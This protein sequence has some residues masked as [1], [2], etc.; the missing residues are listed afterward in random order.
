MDLIV[1]AISAGDL[2]ADTW[3]IAGTFGL[4]AAIYSWWYFILKNFGTF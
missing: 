2:W 1:A 3:R 4:L